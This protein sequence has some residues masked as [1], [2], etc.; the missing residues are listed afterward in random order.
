MDAFF[1]TSDIA[2]QRTILKMIQMSQSQSRRELSNSWNSAADRKC[3]RNR[4]FVY[5]FIF[6]FV[7]LFMRE[8]DFMLHGRKQ[9]SISV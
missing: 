1:N 7:S 4:D 3:S 6:M 9:K 2:R 8:K 5:L